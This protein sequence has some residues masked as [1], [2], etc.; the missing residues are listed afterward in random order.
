MHQ[1]LPGRG[2]SAMLL[3]AAVLLPAG[4][5]AA[6]GATPAPFPAAPAAG[7]CVVAPRAVAEIAAVVATPLSE[8]RTE[9]A[10]T[11]FAIPAGEPAD[12][13][14]TE[15]VVATVR[16]VFACTNAGD[17]RRVFASF[18]DDFL[19]DFLA[20]TP[21]SEEVIALFSAPPQAL[22]VAEQR[23]IVRKGE[24]RLLPD[25]RAG[26]VVVLDEPDDP[27]VEEPDYVILIERDGRWLIDE[28]HED[29]GAPTGTPTP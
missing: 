26:V 13:A 10:A 6:Q 5:A 28:I 8:V 21:L 9:A 27:R 12:A 4:L 22:P 14:T 16:Q 3:C 20:G 18:S 25:G 11:P 17:Y 19:R 24:V 15:A 29:G 7:E 1:S 23:V 2:W